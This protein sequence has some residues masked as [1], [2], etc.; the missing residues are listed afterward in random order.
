VEGM[1]ENKQARRLLWTPGLAT[2]ARGPPS[3]SR[4]QRGPL[5]SSWGQHVALE[6]VTSEQVPGATRSAD[7]VGGPGRIPAGGGPISGPGDRAGAG[8]R[9]QLPSSSAPDSAP[10]SPPALPTPAPPTLGNSLVALGAPSPSNSANPR[11][12]APFFFS[13]MLMTKG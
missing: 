1:T 12:R 5:P 6:V 4:G 8:P 11:P 3:P 7:M 9:G 10:R 13:Y 2:R